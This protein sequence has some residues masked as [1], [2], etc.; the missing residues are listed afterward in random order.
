MTD[1]APSPD[2]LCG[3]GDA[4]GV[5]DPRVIADALATRGHFELVGVPT[6]QAGQHLADVHLAARTAG[7]LIG[8]SV[9]VATTQALIGGRI[10]YEVEITPKAEA[11]GVS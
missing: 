1:D 6:R 3:D 9:A 11:D 10:I 2:A 4:N 5:P 7:R 8:I